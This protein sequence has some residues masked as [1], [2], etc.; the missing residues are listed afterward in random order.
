M[1]TTKTSNP[2]R[3]IAF[4]LTAV[5]LIC[6]FG[7]TVDG[8]QNAEEPSQNQES[9]NDSAQND[10]GTLSGATPPEEETP[11]EPE[12]YIPKHVN[13]LTGL[14]VGEEI[15]NAQPLAFI[16]DSSCDSYGIFNADIICE[17]PIENGKTRLISIITDTTNLWKIGSISP[18]RGYISNIAA[19]FGATILSVGSDD[20]LSYDKCNVNDRMI[21]LLIKSGYHYTEFSTYNY[22]NCDLINAVLNSATQNDL[23]Q[24]AALPFAFQAWDKENIVYDTQASIIKMPESKEKITEIIATEEGGYI[25]NKNGKPLRDG[26]NGET[27]AFENCFILFADSITYDNYDC[28]QMVMNTIGSGK[29][30]Y[31]TNGSLTEINWTST[32]AGV[33]SFYNESGEKLTVN[34]GTSYISYV[35]ASKIGQITFS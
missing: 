14:E 29:G 11:Q 23:T 12:I 9:V 7:F 13:K 10:E 28:E 16:M 1:T 32:T 33:L 27:L 31:I 19:F 20:I 6:M 30:Y 8:W 5:M 21:D 26:L 24:E 18:T 15:A 34:R 3:L 17:V 4:F 35:K 2:V 25:I 22:T